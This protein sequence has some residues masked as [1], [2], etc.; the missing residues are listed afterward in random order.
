MFK[1]IWYSAKSQSKEDF[2][3]INIAE[4]FWTLFFELQPSTKFTDEKAEVLSNKG[5][6]S[7]SILTIWS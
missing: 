3:L 2:V 5:A 7:Q 1:S 4:T 6:K